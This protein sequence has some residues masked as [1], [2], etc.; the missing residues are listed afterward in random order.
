MSQTPAVKARA[1]DD[2]L[3]R[4]CGPVVCGHKAN[5]PVFRMFRDADY[6]TLTFNAHVVA[7][8]GVEGRPLFQVAADDVEVGVV[9]QG[10]TTRSP[11]S[12]PSTSGAP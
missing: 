7:H 2:K 5:S 12:T 10:Q 4:V 6:D 9:P 11:E 1:N 3:A 8:E